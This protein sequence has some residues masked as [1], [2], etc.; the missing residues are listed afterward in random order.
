M[1]GL[2][3]GSVVY[4]NAGIQPPQACMEIWKWKSARFTSLPRL[5][6][7]A[8]YNYSFVFQSRIAY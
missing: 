3:C 1:S 7:H 2:L 4:S 5:R 8:Q 6:V